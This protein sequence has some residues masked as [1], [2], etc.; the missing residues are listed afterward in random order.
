MS[1]RIKILATALLTSMVAIAL[2]VGAVLGYGIESGTKL[3]HR[4]RLPVHAWI[5]HRDHWDP[6]ARRAWRGDLQQWRY[7]HGPICE[8]DNARWR[9]PMG[10]RDERPA[11]R[12]GNLRRLF[13]LTC[14]G[15]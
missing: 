7:L 10:G 4:Q 15:A 14:A 6:S 11:Q 1:A 2:S 5:H 9:R 8:Q 3:L 12:R 13:D